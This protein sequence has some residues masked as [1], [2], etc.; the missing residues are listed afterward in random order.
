MQ[1][2][3]QKELSV[4]A[5][6]IIHCHS[7]QPG[8]ARMPCVLIFTE[9]TVQSTH[10]F[11]SRCVFSIKCPHHSNSSAKNQF[12]W[13]NSFILLKIFWTRLYFQIQVKHNEIQKSVADVPYSDCWAIGA[14]QWTTIIDLLLKKIENK[15][16]FA[17]AWFR[18][19]LRCT[20][21][22]AWSV[23]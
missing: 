16:N 7:I 10:F 19:Q 3:Y 8:G 4:H 22:V 23:N 21:G 2:S 17:Y 9:Q 1:F 12:L 13:N 20:T 15:Y 11:R 14:L 18:Q 5:W 6:R